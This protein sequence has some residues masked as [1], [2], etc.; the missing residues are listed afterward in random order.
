MNSFTKEELNAVLNSPDLP[1]YI[2]DAE[3]LANELGV[4]P[5]KLAAALLG[6]RK[7]NNAKKEKI[8]FKRNPNAQRFFINIGSLEE[9]DAKTLMEIITNQ[10]EEIAKDD[11]SDVYVK[12]KYSFFELLYKEDN[13]NEFLKYFAFEE[14]KSIF[15]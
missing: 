7:M 11:F 1:E 2:E 5:I 14:R 12:D 10:I 6:Q 4:E 3:H 8:Y 9:I 13:T 15:I